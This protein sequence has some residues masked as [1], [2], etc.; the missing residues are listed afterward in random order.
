MEKVII[1]SKNK[2]GGEKNGGRYWVELDGVEIHAV[3]WTGNKGA[4]AACDMVVAFCKE[5][6]YEYDFEF[7]F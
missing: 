1:H 5:N 4:D 7:P 6:G 3:N 2:K